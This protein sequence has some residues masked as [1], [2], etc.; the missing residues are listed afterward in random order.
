MRIALGADHAGYLLKEEIKVFL[1][2]SGYS[3][4]DVGTHSTESVDYPDYAVS[5]SKFVLSGEADRGIL[6]CGSGVGACIAANKLPGI[7]ACLCHD[8]YSASQGVEHDD[9]NVLVLGGRIIGVELAKILVLN[10]L[11]SSFDPQE[12][13]VRRL[14]KIKELEETTDELMLLDTENT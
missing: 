10:F 12:R 3:L 8:A 14:K 9:M 6:V 13:F 11:S 1:K 7:R 2:D 4:M 5:V